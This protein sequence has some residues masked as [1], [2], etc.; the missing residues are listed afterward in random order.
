MKFGQIPPRWKAQLAALA[1]DDRLDVQRRKPKRPQRA[2]SR[3]T[4]IPSEEDEQVELATW[5]DVRGH[6]W[7]HVPNGEL[8]HPRTAARLKAM[9]VKAGVPDILVFTVPPAYP[10]ARG[11]ALELKRRNVRRP[12]PAQ[13]AWLAELGTLGWCVRVCSGAAEAISFLLELGY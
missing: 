5:L 4:P 10:K 9:G 13:A 8:R 1:G 6:V 3:V 2:V 11:V 7:C 12:T